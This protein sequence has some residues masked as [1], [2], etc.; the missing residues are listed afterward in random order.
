M[1]AVVLSVVGTFAS[2]AATVA[3]RVA[4]G[5][6]AASRWLAR[7]L[8]TSPHAAAA[9]LTL[10]AVASY[11]HPEFAWYAA[12]FGLPAGAGL[13]LWHGSDGPP[14]VAMALAPPVP[15]TPA[16]CS[17]GPGEACSECPDAV[18]LDPF[19]DPP[20]HE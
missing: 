2:A 11:W 16:G 19:V 15:L 20:A 3:T 9:A 4:G 5:V 1:V 18:R 17:C 14:R 12:V 7:L 13:L 8:M 6:V 10:L